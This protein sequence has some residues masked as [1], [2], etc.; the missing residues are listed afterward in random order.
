MR[1]GGFGPQWTVGHEVFGVI[2]G[3]FAAGN[4]PDVLNISSYLIWERIKPNNVHN[5]D[6][7]RRME[8]WKKIRKESAVREG[9]LVDPVSN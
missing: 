1:S 7:T 3:P 4:F 8:K 5:V 2:D 9:H 6:A